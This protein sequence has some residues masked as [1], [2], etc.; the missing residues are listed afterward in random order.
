MDDITLLARALRTL[1]DKLSN[2]NRCGL[3]QSVCPV[4]GETLLEGDVA[5]GKLALVNN[6]SHELLAD[7]EAVRDRLGR[8]L[9]CG[10]CHDV[11][12]AGVNT[13]ELF[14]AAREIIH[15]YLGLSPLKK[16]LFRTLL[17][18]ARLLNLLLSA[19]LPFR[20]LVMREEH[21]AQDT[22]Q[23]P[24][25]RKFAG[26]RHL[27]SM[28]GKTLSAMTG[29]INS[30][31]GKSR[32]KVA[33][34]PGCMGNMVYTDMARACLKVFD[35]HEVGVFFPQD[36]VCCGLPALTSGEVDG[37]RK[38]VMH[39]V[40]VFKSGTFDYIVTPCPSCTMTIRD[41]W[42]QRAASLPFAYRDAI[43]EL[44]AK[45][46]DINAFL[47]DVVGV[48]KPQLRNRG[49][50]IIK[51]TFHDPCHLRLSLGITSQPRELIRMNPQYRLAEMEEAGRCCGCGGTFT[52]NEPEL[53]ARIGE[54]K[55][56]NILA[57][58]AEVVATGCPACMMQI[59]DMLARRG[60]KVI[61]RH[62]IEIY[63]EALERR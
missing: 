57:S 3:C 9:L 60:S 24:L 48:R 40:D 10:A 59:S 4:Y 1:D 52:L 49:R 13:F 39:N 8:C 25:L 12:P 32:I 33:F 35:Y 45:A 23:A 56:R 14:L 2:C 43:N 21:N 18:N 47:I 55:V 42:V 22:T 54:R 7:P 34:F 26:D 46:I 17:P 62:A 31:A 27:P 50:K 6:L 16:A 37:F 20:K 41:M 58:Q 30:P 36:F 15:G 5:R 11:C 61:V 44:S 51:A 38:S 29:A 53:S 19:G 63:A 28:P